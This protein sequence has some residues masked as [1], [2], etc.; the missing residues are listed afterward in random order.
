MKHLF[1]YALLV[2]FASSAM[3]TAANAQEKTVPGF[4]P[5]AL[6]KFYGDKR[7]AAQGS[8]SL[9]AGPVHNTNP[10]ETAKTRTC[11]CRGGDELKWGTFCAPPGYYYDNPPASDWNSGVVY[12]PGVFAWSSACKH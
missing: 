11:A 12:E 7:G 1:A 10:P 6:E 9:G 8:S 5:S 4:D 3:I 2:V